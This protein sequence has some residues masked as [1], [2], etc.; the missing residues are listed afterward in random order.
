LDGVRLPSLAHF[1]RGAG[2][3]QRALAARVGAA[4][5]T[6]AMWEGGK[7]PVPRRTASELA[8]ALLVPLDRLAAAPTPQR[9]PRP[10]R[11]LR[12]GAGMTRPEAAA[13]LGISIGTL[14]RYEAGERR[15]P[16]TIARRMAVA[17]GRPA[18]QLLRLCG[19]PLVPVPP[20]R[21]WRPE[22]VPA[23]ITALRTAAGMSKEA[24]GRAVQRSGQ[25]VR[26]WESGR[27]RPSA[28]TCR[29]L[30]TIFRLSSGTLPF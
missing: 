30:E 3:T 27:S 8:K 18:G 9:D 11:R 28:A 21:R 20:G 23:G 10:L 12:N 14:S 4:P 13:H 1:R 19:C 15:V 2:L 29:R 17:Y 7:V 6:F 16:V 25:A 22:D 5:S 24:L 26:G